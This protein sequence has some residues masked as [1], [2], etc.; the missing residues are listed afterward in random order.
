MSQQLLQCIQLVE[1]LS[2]QVWLSV[3]PQ[4]FAVCIFA[5][6]YKVQFMCW[7]A[8]DGRGAACVIYVTLYRTAALLKEH[9]NFGLADD[10]VT[11]IKQE[12]VP[13]LTDNEAR[14]A[15]DPDN[16][17]QVCQQYDALPLVV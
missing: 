1:F 15:L 3:Q 4:Q 9:S 13:A 17:Y 12:K 14:F 5:V 6:C 11:I 10:Q 8:V 16:R 2:E 7:H